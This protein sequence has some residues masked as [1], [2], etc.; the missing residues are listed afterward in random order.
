MKTIF[1]SGFQNE[2]GYIVTALAEDGNA[3][4]QHCCSN[5]SYAEHD[6]GIKG[7]WEH[8]HYDAHYGAG[9]WTLEWVEDP[10]T[11]PGWNAA[12]AKNKELFAEEIK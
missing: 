11:H 12:L 2:I 7:T 5:R 6:I 4:A 3:L 1:C 10:A 8:E 9:N